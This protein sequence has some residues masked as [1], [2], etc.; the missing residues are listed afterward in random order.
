MSET[1]RAIFSSWFIDPKIVAALLVTGILY[2]RGWRVLHRTTPNRFPTSRLFAFLTGLLSLWVAV[3]SPLEALSG[4]L[5]SAHMVQHLLLLVVGPPL[6]LL[7]APLLP[8]LRGLPRGFARH[9]LGPFLSWPALLNLGRSLTH[10]AVCW[11]AMAATLSAWHVPAAFD[12]ALRLPAWHRVEHACFFAAGLLFWWPVARPFP[13][14]PH[15]PPLSIPIYLLAADI[16]NTA[17]SAILT[18]SDRVVYQP[19]RDAP[20]LF[21]TTALSDQAAAGL[22]MWVPGSLVFLVPA[23]VLAVR[24]LSPAGSLIRPG[25]NI[26]KPAPV[27]S[28]QET[29]F[30]APS[31]APF[32]V[33]RIP[34]VGQLLRARPG[35]R[36]LQML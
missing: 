31:N 7:G 11:L 4:L 26:P 34:I 8:L 20:R 12:L 9:G 19:Y 30:S 33:L 2:F 32:D 10:P 22:I 18:F 35:R 1:A 13:S 27:P 14:R 3:A 5:L 28:P 21:G 16:L 23:V 36:I 6:I 24:L 17:L 15:W 29:R 25:A